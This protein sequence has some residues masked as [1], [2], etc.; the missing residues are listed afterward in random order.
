MVRHRPYSGWE[1]Y[2]GRVEAIEIECLFRMD[3]HSLWRTD[4]APGRAGSDQ[5]AVGMGLAE[6]QLNGYSD[7]PAAQPAFNASSTFSGCSAA[8]ATRPQCLR[9]LPSG[10]IH[11]VER[12]TP[13]VFLPYMTFSP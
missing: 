8:L 9:T 1:D 12:M 4:G 7:A 5:Q 6:P 11:T 13:W 3:K 2:R 10:P